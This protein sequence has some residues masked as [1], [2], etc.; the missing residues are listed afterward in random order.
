MWRNPGEIPGNGIDDDGDGYIDDVY[1]IDTLHHD[2]NPMDDEGHGSH[3]AGTIAAVGNNG[4]G[5]V[6]V[7][8]NT[9]ILACKF[10]GA[11]GSG[12]DAGALEC[13]HYITALRNRGEHNRVSSN[14]WG[15]SRGSD[16]PSAV[17]QAAID[18]AGE[19]GIINIFGAGNDGTNNDVSPFDPASYSSPSIVSVAS[20]D[21]TDHRSSFSNYGALSVDI[22]APGEGIMS[23]Y[24]GNG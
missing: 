7:S 18:E 8:W 21:A 24:L 4:L 17:L 3:T 20:S 23:T 9:K 14:S 19:A 16:P 12:T 15:Q 13:F 1:G 2:S 6:G 11:D 10:I 22:A 5:V